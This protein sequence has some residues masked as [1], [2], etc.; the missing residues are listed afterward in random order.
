MKGVIPLI[1]WMHLLWI[2]PLCVLAGFFIAALVI[3][4]EDE[5]DE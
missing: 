5:E 1:Y 2:C 4:P 3:E